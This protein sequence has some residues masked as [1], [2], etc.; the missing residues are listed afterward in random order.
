MSQKVNANI[1]EY[2]TQ[3]HKVFTPANN[4]PNV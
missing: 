3:T 4:V 1:I 2:E